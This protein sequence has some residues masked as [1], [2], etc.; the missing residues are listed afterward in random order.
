MKTIRAPKID[1]TATSLNTRTTNPPTPQGVERVGTS[2]INTSHIT[3]H[4]SHITHHT[5]ATTSSNMQSGHHSS[6]SISQPPA[7]S[8]SQPPAEFTKHQPAT[9][10][11]IK[12]AASIEASNNRII[13][14]SLALK[15]LLRGSGGFPVVP[16]QAARWG[17]NFLVSQP[18]NVIKN[19]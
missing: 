10:T 14:A 2:P 11:K 5:T 16:P 1:R 17:A 15:V 7:L 19:H 9:S 8:S 18:P 3:H 6:L 12:P 13:V 4:T